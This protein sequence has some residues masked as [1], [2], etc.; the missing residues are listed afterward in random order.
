MLVILD[1]IKD[2]SNIGF[3]I[4]LK[5]TSSAYSLVKASGLKNILLKNYVPQKELLN[6][7]RVFAFLS[8]GGANSITEAMYYGTPLLVFPQGHDQFGGAIR[9]S[10]I[11]CGINLGANPVKMTIVKGIETLKPKEGQDNM[12]QKA[13]KRMRKMVEF[14][15]LRQSKDLAYYMRRS[16]KFNQ[17]SN[18]NNS[19]HLMQLSCYHNWSFTYFDHDIQIWMGFV[20]FVIVF[21][22]K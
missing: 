2:L 16:I 7:Q 8:H 13:I 10:E 15:E 18:G 14:K 19:L 5:E 20:I 17:W 11:N 21:A 4:S 1:A 9:V 3:I 22:L 12:Y 6:D